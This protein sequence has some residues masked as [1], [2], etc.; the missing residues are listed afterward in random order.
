MLENAPDP[1]DGPYFDI[2]GEVP[3]EL[4]GAVL[5]DRDGFIWIGTYGSGLH[6]YDGS[7]L[8]LFQPL[9]GALS[10]DNVTALHEDD[11]GIIWI[12]SLG[13]LDRYNKETG[14]IEQATVSGGE[15]IGSLWTI[16]AAGDDLWLGTNGRG[17][18]RYRP[19][20]G[21]MERHR[22][23]DD[24]SLGPVH[25]NIYRIV[26]A[27][28]GRLWIGSFGGG[29]GLFDPESGRTIRVIDSEAGLISDQVWSLYEDLS[30]GVLIDRVR[31]DRPELPVL[32]I[33]GY[34]PEK[35]KLATQ[36]TGPWRLEPKLIRPR[37]V[38]E[39][40]DELLEPLNADL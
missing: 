1:A 5:Q 2:A 26:Q 15:K 39:I 31:L 11:E 17:L 9:A 14:R 13:G 37:R 32:Y 20:N 33:S 6:R 10:D 3:S 30:G 16:C 38:V 36:G 21:R 40:L 4:S 24:R 29:A 19:A 28:D 18:I 7:K 22:A 25:D 27:R 34:A 8:I 12:A 35:V 23:S